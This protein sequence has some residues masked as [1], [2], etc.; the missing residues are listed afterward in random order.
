MVR[1]ERLDTDKRT[2]EFTMRV[3]EITKAAIDRLSPHFK[4]RLNDR[5]LVTM[6]AV[7]HEATF[8]PRRYLIADYFESKPDAK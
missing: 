8:D 6:A 7:I 2:E 3:P 1:S 5:I 4:R